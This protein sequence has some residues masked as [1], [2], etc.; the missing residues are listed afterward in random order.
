[1]QGD[2]TKTG[3]G[4]RGTGNGERGT[5]NG[6]WGT[7]NEHEKR[8]NENR[9]CEQSRELENNVVNDRAIVLSF[10]LSLFFFDSLLGQNC[11][12]E[13]IDKKTYD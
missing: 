2:V 9:K 13:R 7:G 11:S 6:E 5:G 1:M 10:F 12:H 3:K 4:E 8:E